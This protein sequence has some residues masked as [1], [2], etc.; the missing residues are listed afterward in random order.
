MYS[1]QSAL[2][3]VS[4]VVSVLISSLGLTLFFNA[5]QA[6]NTPASWP[7]PGNMDPVLADR[8]SAV[9]RQALMSPEIKQT[10][11]TQGNEVSGAGPKEYAE[12]VKNDYKRWGDVI[13]HIGLTLD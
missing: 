13:K 5:A 6:Q 11:A 10:V 3:I 7:A 2:G 1:M 4:P 12:I 8:I 9:F